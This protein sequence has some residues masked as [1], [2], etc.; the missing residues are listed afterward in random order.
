MSKCAFGVP[1]VEYLGHFISGEGESTDPKK[2]VVV[3]Q[4]PIPGNIKQLMGFLG[5][6]GYYRRFIQGFG[7][8]CKSLHELLKKDGYT[9][10]EHATT[11]F[12]ELKQALI[13]A[14]VLAMPDYSKPFVVETDASRK[15]IGVVLMQQ[16]HPI[17]YIS[18]SL[19]PRHQAMSVYD[20]ELMALIFAVAG[21]PKLMAFD[22][23]IEYKK[24]ID[25]KVVDALSRK[26]G[27]ELLSISLLTPN[28]SL[29]E[30]IKGTWLTDASLQTLITK[31]QA[32]PFKSFAWCSAQLRWKGRLRHKYDVFAYPGLLQLLPIPDGVWTDVCLDFIEGLPKSNGKSVILVVVDRLSK[33]GHF[34]S[35]QHPYTAQSVAQ[36][37]L[38][39]V[40]KLHG[41]PAT[42]TSDRDPVFLSKFWQKLFT[43][44][45]VQ[46]QRSTAYHPQTDGQMEVLN[47]ILETYLRCFCSDSP[48]EWSSYLPLAEWWYNTTYHTA[49]K[50]TPYEVLYGQKPPIH[51][52][53]LVG[54][55]SSDMVDRS[56]AAREAS[57]HLLKFHI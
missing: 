37:F 21:I 39:N 49:I 11:T 8:I 45:G 19:A 33:Y 41:I 48:K 13:S 4:W 27:A 46:L 9:W 14:P 40:F 57:I 44:Q 25:N 20:R 38:D 29:Y 31:L 42:L 26:P 22:F 17:A 52:S 7:S 55:S 5:L 23:S 43:I 30:Q 1:K 2:I 3:A 47:R 34:M 28:D 16:G 36:C 56:L 50:C 32:Q 24:G 10:T 6:A 35:L 12:E 15:G 18:R 54:E 53:Y 51:L